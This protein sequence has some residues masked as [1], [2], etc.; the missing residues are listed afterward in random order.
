MPRCAMGPGQIHHI[1]LNRD[2]Y[3]NASDRPVLKR[4][5][6]W[7]QSR[8]SSSVLRPAL[9]MS[10]NIV[11][12]NRQLSCAFIWLAAHGCLYRLNGIQLV[13]GGQHSSGG[14][15]HLLILRDS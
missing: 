1:Y 15:G 2:S 11:N 10:R 3:W 13:R 4:P 12:P 5:V 6:N 9:K 7:A 8:M 14:I